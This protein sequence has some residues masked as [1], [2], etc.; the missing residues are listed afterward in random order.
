MQGLGEKEIIKFNLLVM[1]GRVPEED[2]GKVARLVGMTNIEAAD[3]I[4]AHHLSLN[5]D[6]FDKE[7]QSASPTEKK[8]NPKSDNAIKASK[9]YR[10]LQKTQALRVLKE[11]VLLNQDHTCLACERKVLTRSEHE[12][13]T[14]EPYPLVVRCVFPPH[15]YIQ[16]K[17]LFDPKAA[18][19]DLK[20]LDPKYYVALCVDCK[21]MNFGG[22]Q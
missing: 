14:N 4:R 11:E 18:C 2:A 20:L 16:A 15:K 9:A 3:K 13:I 7:D 19:T 12:K 17:G 10:A 6:Y 1:A 22:K 5:K 8:E 21:P